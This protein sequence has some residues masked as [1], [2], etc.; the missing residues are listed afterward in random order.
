M[1]SCILKET[2]GDFTCSGGW[3][4]I[5]QKKLRCN[6]RLMLQTQKTL[7]YIR[8]MKS[9]QMVKVKFG[10]H[11]MN[12]ANHSHSKNNCLVTYKRER[13]KTPTTSP[14]YLPPHLCYLCLTQ[15]FLSLSFSSH[16]YFSRSLRCLSPTEHAQF[17]RQPI[18]TMHE[19]NA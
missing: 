2:A 7:S 9:K 15:F 14:L 17:P 13:E 10:R 6:K 18:S 19:R 8:S 12:K 1:L 5:V 16:Q 11:W 4:K 3:Q